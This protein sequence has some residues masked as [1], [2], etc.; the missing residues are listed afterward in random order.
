MAM[1]KT[2]RCYAHSEQNEKKKRGKKKRAREEAATA[3]CIGERRMS[4]LLRRTMRRVR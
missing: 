1:K 2:L 4:F 3:L